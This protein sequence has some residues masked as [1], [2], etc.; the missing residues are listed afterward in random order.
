MDLG[1]YSS[2]LYL[3]SLDILP[4]MKKRLDSLSK[5]KNPQQKRGFSLETPVF[6]IPTQGWVEPVN[7]LLLAFLRH[8]IEDVAMGDGAF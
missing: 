8:E 1:S 7:P 6:Q 2:I 3:K 5:K 4:K